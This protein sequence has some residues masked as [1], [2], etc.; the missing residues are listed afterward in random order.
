M[1]RTIRI[2][3]VGLVA[4]IWTA[5][6]AYPAQTLR[7]VRIDTAAPGA[8]AQRLTEAGFDM[9]PVGAGHACEV[10]VSEAELEALRRGGLAP[11]VIAAGQPFRDIQAG[12]LSIQAVLSGYL[13]LAD[14]PAGRESDFPRQKS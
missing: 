8:L 4:G 3:A 13:E 6:T 10:I 2:L 9:L 11:E 5:G 7:L 14:L 12:Q 1:K